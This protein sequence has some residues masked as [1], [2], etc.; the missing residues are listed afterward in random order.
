MTMP[1][2]AR[3]LGAAFALGAAYAT[4]ITAAMDEAKWITVHP[5]GKGEGKGRPALIDSESGVVLGGMGGKFNGKKLSEMKSRPA[6]KP[7]GGKKSA[8][9]RAKID[10]SHPDKIDK[11][12]IIQNRDRSNSGSIQQINSIAA[13]PDYMRMG[14]SHDLANGAPV[15][16]Y[17]SVDD[18]HLGNPVT[19]VDSDGNR[20]KMQYAVV[21]AS[22][23]LTSNDAQGNRNPDYESDDASRMRAVAGNGRM[24]GITEGY[25]RGTADEYRQ[26]MIDDAAASGIDPETV[27]GMKNPVLVRVMQ[28]S[29]VTPDI[30]D[31]TNKQGGLSMTA[32]E[33]AKNDRQRI[34]LKDIETYDD[35]TPTIKSLKQWI[36]EQP[37]AERGQMLGK[38][39]EPTKQAM[40]RFQAAIF[41]KAYDNDYLTEMYGQ[42]LD[43]QCKTIINGLEK[44]APKMVNLGDAPDGYDIRDI[45]G[46]ATEKVVQA[47]RTG[48]SLEDVSGQMDMFNSDEKDDLARAIVKM[49][50]KNMRSGA[51]IGDK[52]SALAEAMYAEGQRTD[53]IFGAVE[54]VPPKEIFKQVLGEDRKPGKMSAQMSAFWHKRGGAFLDAFFSGR[55]CKTFFSALRKE[56]SIC[57]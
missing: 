30:G 18:E 16:A 22:D 10:L 5:N 12:N 39:G 38:N 46:M 2:K 52:L 21:E 8:A 31:R 28:A 44:A 20:Y 50:A 57:R 7:S 40:E 3:R 55:G 53:D 36:A 26:E 9:S 24:T 13:K 56:Y 23:V 49:Y 42:A 29:D 35:G 32:V 27:K 15:V 4:G 33:Q 45:I 11:S 37:V 6:A 17:G 48:M 19:V 47:K 1:S 34:N 51:A 14:P 25:N 43:P 54:H 41:S